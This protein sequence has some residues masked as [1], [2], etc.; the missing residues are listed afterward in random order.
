[1]FVFLI[2]ADIY[3][4]FRDAISIIASGVVIAGGIAAVYVYW[5]W[6]RFA[7]SQWTIRNISFYSPEAVKKIFRIERRTWQKAAPGTTLAPDTLQIMGED[8]QWIPV[9]G[10]TSMTLTV[11]IIPAAVL[12]HFVIANPSIIPAAVKEVKFTLTRLADGVK[13]QFAP[14]HYGKKEGVDVP[15][16]PAR[17]QLEDYWGSILIPP[18]SCK[19]HRLVFI[20]APLR[21]PFASDSDQVFTELIAGEYDCTVELTLERLFRLLKHSDK[22]RHITRRINLTELA[23]EEWNQNKPVIV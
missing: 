16:A 8:K 15:G 23:V 12:V 6:T 19:A 1:M 7:R 10:L 22:S 4:A 20:P 18:A 5:S 3:L 2:A 11:N 17:V 13:Y 9:K 21:P 14:S